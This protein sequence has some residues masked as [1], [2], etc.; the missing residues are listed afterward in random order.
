VLSTLL[1]HQLQLGEL[2]SYHGNT[3]GDPADWS[4]YCHYSRA[5]LPMPVVPADLPEVKTAVAASIGGE[6]MTLF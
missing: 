3:L 4:T 6:Q 2:V 1:L 5:D